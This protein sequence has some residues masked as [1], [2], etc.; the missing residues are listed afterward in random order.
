MEE[1]K[2]TDEESGEIKG[3]IEIPEIINKNRMILVI[4]IVTFILLS[5][6]AYNVVKKPKSDKETITLGDKDKI[7]VGTGEE[8]IKEENELTEEE[9]AEIERIKKEQEEAEKI[10]AGQENV[11][12]NPGYENNVGSN[13][14]YSDDSMF[15]NS[16]GF[17]NVNVGSTEEENVNTVSN[18][19]NVKE[20]KKRTLSA[21]G[22]NNNN[23]NAQEIVNSLES[24]PQ[25]NKGQMTAAPS[26][27]DQNRQESKRNFISTQRT[28]SF[29][30]SNVKIPAL[31]RYEIKTGEL[32][33]AVLITGITSDLPGDVVAQITRDVKDYRTM[34]HILIPMGTR[35]IGKYDSSITYG[36]DR[37]LVVW[38][39]LV[40]PD[41]STLALDNMQGVDLV[42]NA[43]LKGKV[44]NHFWKLLRSVVLS[45]G[46]NMAAGA[47]ESVNVNVNS[48]S[49]S[50]VTVGT[51]ASDAANNVKTIGERLVE[52]DLNR[53]PTIIIKQG[54]RFNIFV[55]K[56]IVLSPYKRGR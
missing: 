1:R 28:E 56:D 45:A 11:Y 9:K 31:G 42:G 48:S 46:I 37:V 50:R 8:E 23:S 3:K 33:S 21:L 36:Q 2:D 25:Q 17:T 13:F 52:K 55:N 26:E 4:G 53:Q 29:Y 15:K 5:I 7:K 12:V 39:R 18:S 10:K 54:S 34:K 49:K 30:S 47:L 24:L 22:E 43:G 6:V 14:N 41:G 20:N 40:F 35:V 27:T 19:N 16:G 51:G 38:Q 44:N 32:I